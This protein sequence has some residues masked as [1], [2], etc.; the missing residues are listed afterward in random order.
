M[1]AS[2]H[3]T[4]QA[5]RG[6]A[7]LGVIV[8]VSNTNLEPDMAL[9]APRGVTAHFARAG[10]YDVDAVPDETQMRAYSD[11]AIDDV[12]AQLTPAR[13]DMVLYGCTSATLAQ[14][15][16]YDR[17][18][19]DRLAAMSGAPVISAASALA[20]GLRTM[21]VARYAFVSPYV[22]SLNDLAI[23][24]LAEDGPVCVS[25]FDTERPWSNIDVGSAQPDKVIEMARAGDS[26]EAEAMVISCTDFRAVEA[27]DDLEEALGKPVLTSNQAMMVWA[28]A[29]L[30]LPM[31][32]SFV[33]R[34]ALARRC[35]A[36]GVA[37]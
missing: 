23:D 6:R 35:Q 28:L 4:V 34:H 32:T 29:K 33:R 2:S 22:K 19:R 12:I 15:P 37:A 20:W 31:D 25:R 11:N 13:P 36:H 14:G 24:F 18:F 27:I 5:S 8:P 7:R 16:A 1:R 21:G 17:A 3:S 26:P 9:M 10:G 30:Q